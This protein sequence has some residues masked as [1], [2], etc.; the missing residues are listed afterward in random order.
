MINYKILAES[1]DYYSKFEFRAIESP[2]TVSRAV[3]D[4]TRPERCNPNE[5]VHN[6][7][8]LVGSGEQ[9][10]IYMMVKGFLPEGQYQTITPCFRDE[11]FDLTHRKY[12]MKNELIIT[13][14]ASKSALDGMVLQA[15]QF[16]RKYLPQAVAKATDLDRK[17]YDILWNDI[18]LGSY[19]I[20]TH[21]HLSW[22]YGTGVAEP[23]LSNCIKMDYG[24]SHNSN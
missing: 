19:G 20:R 14:T 6:G 13:G 4:V 9:S 8:C 15:L 22:I 11:S 12:F 5:L 7:K 23:R 3:S 10:F 16:F 24:I 17:S 21:K 2:W 1:Q 18:E